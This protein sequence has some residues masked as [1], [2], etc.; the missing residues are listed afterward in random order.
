MVLSHYFFTCGNHVSNFSSLKEFNDGATDN[1]LYREESVDTA[2][3]ED[4]SRT[5][6][7]LLEE[8]SKLPYRYGEVPSEFINVPL[9]DI[10]PYYKDKLTFIV[11]KKGDR[12]QRGGRILR[13]TATP[14]LFLLSPFHPCRRL[15]LSICRHWWFEFFVMMTILANCYFLIKAHDTYANALEIIFTCIYTFEAM[16]KVCGRGFLICKY[17]FL[18]FCCQN[19]F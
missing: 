8:G 5:P 1:K 17:L 12:N 7:P 19:T 15:A 4:I 14:S 9:C 3:A 6:D 2:T 18:S 10:D 13:Y 16:V 11:I